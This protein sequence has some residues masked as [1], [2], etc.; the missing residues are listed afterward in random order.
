MNYTDRDR[1]LA[2]AGIYQAVALVQQIA[3]KGTADAT[4]MACSI[5][6][7]FLTAP[8]STEAVYGAIPR[9]AL[10]LRT[11][12]HQL[13]G[14]DRRDKELTGYLLS[15]IQLERKLARRTDRLEQISQGIQRTSRR[16]QHFPELHGNILAALADIYAQNISS[17]Q[18]RIMVSGEPVY[19]QNPDNVHRIRALLLAGIRSAM[20][21]RQTGGRRRELLLNRTKYTQMASKILDSTEPPADPGET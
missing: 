20:L 15:L 17:L 6:S 16:L 8:E 4:A 21:W 9:L 10:G 19:L 13:N 18:P 1:T 2:L 14:E 11:L 3:R 7:L 12:C 5:H